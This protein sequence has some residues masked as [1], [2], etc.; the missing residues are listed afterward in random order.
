MGETGIS[1]AEAQ[2][3]KIP[4]SFGLANETGY[5]HQGHLDFAAISLTPTTGTLSLRGIFPNPDGKILPGL[6]ARVRAPV[7]G[8]EKTALLIPEV[9]IGYDQLGSYVLVV[10]R[11]K[12][13]GAPF[14]PT[15]RP[16]GDRRVVKEGL[17]GEEWVI[18]ER[19]DTGLSRPAGDPRPPGAAAG[20]GKVRC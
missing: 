20:A 17:T 13:G 15:G 19:A 8:S 16:G 4:L 10:E 9:A 2:K 6:F 3:I 14:G 7:V 1:A 12:P 11:Q 5:P 18:V